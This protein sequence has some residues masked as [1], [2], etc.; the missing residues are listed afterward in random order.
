[1]IT[2]R[3][4]NTTPCKPIQLFPVLQRMMPFVT[5]RGDPKELHTFTSALAANIAKTPSNYFQSDDA[6]ALDAGYLMKNEYETPWPLQAQPVEKNQFLVICAQILG[7]IISR[8]SLVDWYELVGRPLTVLLPEDSR[9]YNW[10]DELVKSGLK[11][12]ILRENL[13][14][15]R[16]ACESLKR[17]TATP[18]QVE[19]L[20]EM[21]LSTTGAEFARHEITAYAA[22]IEE[23]IARSSR[24]FESAMTAEPTG[25]EITHPW[26]DR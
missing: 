23:S 17:A 2:K 11:L 20:H 21:S 10:D 4:S 6:C 18:E 9:K 1:M 16:A 12:G 7:E 15:I 8:Q 3:P 22:S 24:A 13:S 5:Q 19:V 25:K 14:R 26:R